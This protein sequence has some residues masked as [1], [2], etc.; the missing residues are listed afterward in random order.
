MLMITLLH[1]RSPCARVESVLLGSDR[2]DAD[3][4]YTR[5]GQA[6]RDVFSSRGLLMVLIGRGVGK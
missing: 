5:D 4:G 6:I 2:K 3:K 1:P